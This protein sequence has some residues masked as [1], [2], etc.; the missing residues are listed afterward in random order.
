MS[1]DG[2][3][4]NGEQCE[5]GVENSYLGRT[6][7]GESDE[8]AI[9]RSMFDDLTGINWGNRENWNDDSD[10]CTWYG[11]TCKDDGTVSEIVLPNNMLAGK[12]PSTVFTLKNLEVLNL[13]GNAVEVAFDGTAPERLK[14][15]YLS[16]NVVP[17]LSGIGGA[18]A[19]A[20]E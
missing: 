12:L 19:L 1:G 5:D 11:I 13:K 17:S 16:E 7:C 2:E 6:Q 4:N 9:L 15:L 14:V 18:E 20:S 8:R 3:L 10:I